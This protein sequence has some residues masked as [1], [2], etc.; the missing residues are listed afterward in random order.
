MAITVGYLNVH[1]RR[2][3]SEGMLDRGLDAVGFAE[4]NKLRRPLR[5]QARRH[6]YDVHVETQSS[7][8]RGS[9]ETPLLVDKRLEVAGGLTLRIS[10]EIPGDTRFAPNR[11]ETVRMIEHPATRGVRGVHGIG[12]VVTHLNAGPSILRNPRAG[13]EPRVREYR[14]S[15]YSLARTCRFLRGEGFLPIVLADVNLPDHVDVAWSPYRIL[16]R[17]GMRHRSRN[18]DAVFV[19]ER[20]EFEAFVVVPRDASLSDHPALIA[21]VDVHK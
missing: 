10:E 2:A 18:V 19:D 9:R 14:E 12:V 4:A 17:Q 8:P 7:D 16:E 20:L 11:W 5:R 21:R 15:V 6:G 13:D 3:A 1:N